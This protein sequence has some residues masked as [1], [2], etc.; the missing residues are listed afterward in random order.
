MKAK[1]NNTSNELLEA[2]FE[3][4]E[5]LLRTKENQT[6]SRQNNEG[7]SDVSDMDEKSNADDEM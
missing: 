3:E 7:K 2:E 1:I 5:E 6:S 4:E